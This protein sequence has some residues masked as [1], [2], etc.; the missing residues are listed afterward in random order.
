[1]IGASCSDEDSNVSQNNQEKGGILTYNTGEEFGSKSIPVHYFIPKGDKNEMKVQVIIHGNERNAREYIAAWAQ[2]AREYGLI[3]LAPEFSE[4]Q[5]NSS[6]FQEGNAVTNGK[7]NAP[8]KTTFY[9]LDKIFEFSKEELPFPA[10]S[11]YVYGHSAGAQFVHRMV[12]FY[13]SSYLNKAVSANAGWYTF[14]NENISYPYGIKSL[15][16][17]SKAFR[18]SFFQKDLILLLGTADTLRTG[19]LRITAQ[20]DSQGRNRLERGNNF[21]GFCEDK[22]RVESH[23]F[24]WKLFYVEDTGHDHVLMSKAAADVLYK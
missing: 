17:D 10:T 13:E 8:E 16:T 4:A 18:K 12:E 21:F 14:P 19:D 2:K 3:L 22:A 24:N 6:L 1:M 20:A 9:L 23:S 11:F 7:L 5:F 15:V